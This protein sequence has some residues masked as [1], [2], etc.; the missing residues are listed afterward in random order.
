MNILHIVAPDD[1]QVLPVWP[2]MCR[3][4]VGRGGQ[5]RHLSHFP[6][7]DTDSSSSLALALV[8]CP[9]RAPSSQPGN[10]VTIRRAQTQH[11]TSQV[12]QPIVTLNTRSH[13]LAKSILCLLSQCELDHP[14][15][16]HINGFF[17]RTKTTRTDEH[18][19]QLW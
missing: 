16:L 5:W 3:A 13:E 11:N 9:H 1:L 8:T 17:T 7:S 6:R 14:G 4:S 2:H 10:Y 15:S 12:S 18:L 19:A